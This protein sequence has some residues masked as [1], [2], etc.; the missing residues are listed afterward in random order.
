MAHWERAPGCKEGIQGKDDK[1]M[2]SPSQLL[3]QE[4][5]IHPKFHGTWRTSVQEDTA[6][7]SGK[8]LVVPI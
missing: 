2:A 1:S 6:T 3:E 7:V 8:G 4:V 5:H